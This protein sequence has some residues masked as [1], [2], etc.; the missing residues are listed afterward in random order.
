MMLS[1]RLIDGEKKYC[2]WR[3]NNNWC[4]LLLLPLMLLLLFSIRT[5]DWIRIVV[6]AE[7][8]SLAVL[9]LIDHICC[10]LSWININCSYGRLVAYWL[11][12]LSSK[13]VLNKICP[14]DW[15]SLLKAFMIVYRNMVVTNLPPVDCLDWLIDWWELR[16]C[17]HSFVL[18]PHNTFTF[19]TW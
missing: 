8:S 10:W 14:H 19:Q 12:A 18:T 13:K 5:F 6:V 9:P 11:V 3:L 7:P 16:F 17:F 4:E 2:S 15:W 1:R